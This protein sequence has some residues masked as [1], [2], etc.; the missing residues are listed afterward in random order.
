MR[1]SQNLLQKTL[2]LLLEAHRYLETPRPHSDLDV[3]PAEFGTEG[4]RQLRL[5]RHYVEG[6]LLLTLRLLATAMR[7]QKAC[8]DS[9]PA[10]LVGPSSKP[11]CR[12]SWHA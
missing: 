9:W 4:D 3:K 12:C 2:D 1:A 10:P 6:T 7:K 11:S 8:A 5:E